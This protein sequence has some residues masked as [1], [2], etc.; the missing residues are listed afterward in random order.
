[1]AIERVA[2]SWATKHS[3]TGQEHFTYIIYYTNYINSRDVQSKEPQRLD[4]V[5]EK[6][7]TNTF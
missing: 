6:S 3:T 5:R 1:M 2:K 7:L 4:G